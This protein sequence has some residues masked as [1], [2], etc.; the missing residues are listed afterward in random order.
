M[1]CLMT[2]ILG[3]IKTLFIYFAQK[4]LVETSFSLEFSRN[5]MKTFFLIQY[6]DKWHDYSDKII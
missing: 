1:K 6:K 4:F 3:G 2:S 5:S